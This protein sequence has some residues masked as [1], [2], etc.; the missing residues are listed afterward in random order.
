MKLSY[1]TGLLS[2]FFLSSV[3]ASVEP[4]RIY[5]DDYPPHSM[6]SEDN[7]RVIGASPAVA[8]ALFKHASITDYSI[9]LIQFSDAMEKAENEAYSGILTLARS[10]ER[11]PK[12]KWVG[13][14]FRDKWYVYAPKDVTIKGLR[15]M[16][17]GTVKGFYVATALKN[18]GY[19]VKEYN[20]PK[21]LSEAFKAGDVRLIGASYSTWPS[22]REKLGPKAKELS[23]LIQFP[24]R[25]PY[26]IAFS[27]KTPT[28]L[29]DKLNKVISKMKRKGVIQ[30][31]YKKNAKLETGF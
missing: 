9:Q 10:P 3:F 11:E 20:T 31:I 23:E 17:V 24:S 26:Y 4:L 12:F 1:V 13:P 18:E 8:R 21:E 22:F 27:K 19:S 28:K 14:I 15:D 25:Y 16:S 7:K 5:C 2:L 29:I 30:D 6:M